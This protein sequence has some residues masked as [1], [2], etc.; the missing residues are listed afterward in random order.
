MPFQYLLL[1]MSFRGWEAEISSRHLIADMATGRHSAENLTDG[2]LHFVCLGRLY[3]FTRTPF[4]M[5]NAG[6]TFLRAMQQILQPLCIFADSF[7]DDCA[8]SFDV[9][10][11]HLVTLIAICRLSRDLKLKEVSVCQANGKILRRSHRVWNPTT[12][13]G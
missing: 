3:E 4:G 13:S 2:C 8:V 11:E 5:K 7:V 6:K 9:W 12:G 1:K 10:L